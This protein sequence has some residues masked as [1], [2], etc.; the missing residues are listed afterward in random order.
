MAMASGA[1]LSSMI[2]VRGLSACRRQGRVHAGW[3]VMPCALGQAG[4]RAIKREGD[5]ATPVGT[6]RPV[7]VY[8]RPDRLPRPCTGLPLRALRHDDGWC[9]APTDRN[10]NRPVRHPYPASA[11]AMWRAD[12]LYDLVLVIDHNRRPRVRGAGSAI[13]LHLAREGFA[14]TAGCVALRRPDMIRLIARLR[15]ATRIRILG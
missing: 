5:G 7:C 6:F 1:S 9:D 2:T 15:G 10:Y 13:F 4:R 11:E 8:Y 12:H 3:A 14:P